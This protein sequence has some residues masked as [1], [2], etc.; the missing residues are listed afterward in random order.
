MGDSSHT[1]IVPAESAMYLNKKNINK[2]QLR[3]FPLLL[4]KNKINLLFFLQ[5]RR[6]NLNL[7]IILNRSILSLQKKIIRSI[8]RHYN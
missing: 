5:E 6:L 2:N 8:L 1:R 3:F 7:T 4:R